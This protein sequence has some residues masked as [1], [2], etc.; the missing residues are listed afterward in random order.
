MRI[1]IRWDS[2]FIFYLKWISTIFFLASAVVS[3]MNIIPLNWILAIVGAAGWAL[4][5]FFW[6]D[7]ITNCTKR[8]YC[9]NVI[10]CMDELY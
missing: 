1:R 6:K 4:V 5:G 3:A 10:C 9:C 7:R 2:D 8:V